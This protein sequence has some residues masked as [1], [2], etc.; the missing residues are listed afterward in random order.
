VQVV[1]RSRGTFSIL[2]SVQAAGASMQSRA[3]IFD[4]W[5]RWFQRRDLTVELTFAARAGSRIFRLRR[6]RPG[7]TTQPAEM[8]HAPGTTPRG[9]P[10]C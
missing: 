7:A 1:V 5:T 3:T 6:E 8:P 4:C 2:G 10:I 9:R